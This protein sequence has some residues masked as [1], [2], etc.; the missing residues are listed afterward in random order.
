[1]RAPRSIR[2]LVSAET[3]SAPESIRAVVRAGAAC[4]ALWVVLFAGWGCP[5]FVNMA[6]Q[7][8]VRPFEQA[9]R[10]ASPN[11]VPV[12]WPVR[13]AITYE[14]ATALRNPSSPSDGSVRRGQALYTT[15]CQVCH[16][17]KGAGDGPVVPKF[18]RPPHLMGA[19]RGYTDGYIYALI[20]N[21]RGMMPSYGRIS[22]E[23]RWDVINYLR[24]LQARP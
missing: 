12:D 22:P 21:G 5:W 19:S 14:E 10:P 6:D 24:R 9:P 18:V 1:M 16:G 23:E 20:T 3:R 13:P 15:Y 7:P 4:V 11:T 2:L 8:S 17:P